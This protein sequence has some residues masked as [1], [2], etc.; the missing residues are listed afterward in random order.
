[1][2]TDQHGSCNAVYALLLHTFNTCVKQ[3]MS[4]RDTVCSTYY[5]SSHHD[6]DDKRCIRFTAYALTLHAS[7][8]T[9]TTAQR[10]LPLRQRV[11]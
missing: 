10:S 5:R 6:A 3:L 11:S 1:M 7:T 2:S 4:L 9:K 8:M